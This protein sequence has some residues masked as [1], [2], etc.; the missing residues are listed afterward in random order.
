MLQGWGAGRSA[1]AWVGRADYTCSRKLCSLGPKPWDQ[2]TSNTLAAPFPVDALHTPRPG[3]GDRVQRPGCCSFWHHRREAEW[4]QLSMA[5]ARGTSWQTQNQCERC[6][7]FQGSPPRVEKITTETH[8]IPWANIPFSGAPVPPDGGAMIRAKG[9][10]RSQED[11]GSQSWVEQALGWGSRQHQGLSQH[12]LEPSVS[13][14]SD[15]P[16]SGELGETCSE[17][18]GSQA[19]HLAQCSLQLAT[20]GMCGRWQGRA[21][22]MFLFVL[23]PGLE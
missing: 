14:L 19:G 22:L 15:L 12:T 20:Q 8:P 10:H 4:E 9:A 21:L 13:A 3:W 11:G 17:W 6:G 16:W 7:P 2:E 1:G 5:R 23:P 18:S